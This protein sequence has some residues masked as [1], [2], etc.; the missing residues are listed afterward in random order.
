LLGNFAKYFAKRMNKN[1]ELVLKNKTQTKNFLFKM[2]DWPI[3]Q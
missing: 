2:K 3:F 1:D